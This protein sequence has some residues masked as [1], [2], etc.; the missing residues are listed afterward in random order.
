MKIFLLT[1]IIISHYSFGTI[2]AGKIDNFTS[3][4][5]SI[6]LLNG[7]YIGTADK[8]DTKVNKGQ[9]HFKFQCD[10]AR[11]VKLNDLRIYI[12]PNDSIYLTFDKNNYRKTLT[13]YHDR[14]NEN[15][16]QFQ[17]S[18]KPKEWEHLDEPKDFIYQLNSDLEVLEKNKVN[19][20][21]PFFK[22]YRLDLQYLYLHS[23]IFKGFVKCIV[24]KS[25]EEKLK[26]EPFLEEWIANVKLNNPEALESQ[27]YHN[28][29]EKYATFQISFKGL[30]EE[31]L[32][33]EGLEFAM[34][35][36]YLNDL[37]GEVLEYALGNLPARNEFGTI[38]NDALYPLYDDFIEK[39][40]KS[41]FISK[42]RFVDEL[43]EFQEGN[44]FTAF[45][46]GEWITF[47]SFESF[48]GQLSDKPIYIDFWATWC[49]PCI[50]QFK[51]L[52]EIKDSF[53]NRID[54]LYISID[55][56]KNKDRVFQ[57]IKRFEL[58]GHNIILSDKK[59]IH[60]L[61]IRGIPRYMI[62]DA[63][64]KIIDSNAPAPSNKNKL[65][66]Q[67]EKALD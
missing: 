20:S 57:F 58:R 52:P 5:V 44:E 4:S 2:I 7:H 6:V 23:A 47:E 65:T 54:Y 67:I 55:E 27:E 59:T 38:R 49:K 1:F 9:F 17:Q 43:N 28:Y 14:Q 10:K 63:N 30:F 31:H 37:N 62:A 21:E 51:Y 56:M 66:Q 32:E 42:L 35:L 18:I 26:W 61:G 15:Y 41:V 48:L 34:A 16:F 8:I 46:E 19:F 36:V 60:E 11:F 25:E 53:G 33:N 29:L 40:P 64:G 3:D 13:F 12:E 39:F 24:N 50:Q 22:L 45:L